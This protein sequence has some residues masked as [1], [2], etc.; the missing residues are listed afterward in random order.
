MYYQ[1]RK[2]RVVLCGIR[3]FLSSPGDG[4]EHASSVQTAHRA[5]KPMATPSLS[6]SCSTLK[7]RRSES[8]IPRRRAPGEYKCIV[9]CEH[10]YIT[11]C[12]Y[13]TMKLFRHKYELSRLRKLL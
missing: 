11:P 5:H 6:C 7:V 12:H 1:I 13:K 4:A 8:Q 2:A 3:V 10:K 9:P